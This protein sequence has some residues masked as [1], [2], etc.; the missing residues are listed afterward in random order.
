MGDNHLGI[1]ASV[2]GDLILAGSFGLLQVLLA[3]NAV[4][5]G[6]V[7]AVVFVPTLIV[8]VVVLREKNGRKGLLVSGLVLASLLYLGVLA[9]EM[10]NPQLCVEFVP[11]TKGY[12]EEVLVR[13]RAMIP[14]GVGVVEVEFRDAEGAVVRRTVD[15]RERERVKGIRLKIPFKELTQKSAIDLTV[16]VDP[17]NQVREWNE[18][19]KDRNRMEFIKRGGVALSKLELTV[20][21]LETDGQRVARSYSLASKPVVEVIPGAWHVVELHLPMG[22][23]SELGWVGWQEDHE[24]VILMQAGYY[25]RREARTPTVFRYR[26]PDETELPV[27]VCL[28][29]NGGGEPGDYLVTFVPVAEATS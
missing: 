5:K 21:D 25:G 16:E 7:F 9:C 18:A 29:T 27:T 11:G 15:L 19:A 10:R 2:F 23:V 3:Q 17:D 4:Y 22:D 1:T 28:K 12:P 26:A 13:D 24:D 20:R 6:L 14:S 8:L